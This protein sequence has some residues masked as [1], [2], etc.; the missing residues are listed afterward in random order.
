MLE[1]L[2]AFNQG[3]Y[4]VLPFTAQGSVTFSYMMLGMAVG[5]AVATPSEAEMS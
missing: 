3:L 5:F 1:Y 4:N 2:Q